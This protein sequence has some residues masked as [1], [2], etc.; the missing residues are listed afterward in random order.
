MYGLLTRDTLV[1]GLHV[2]DKIF[3]TRLHA[4]QFHI[5]YA[6]RAHLSAGAPPIYVISDVSLAANGVLHRQTTSSAHAPV[7]R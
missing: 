3:A 7:T 4:K 1:R 2:R 5:G 6:D